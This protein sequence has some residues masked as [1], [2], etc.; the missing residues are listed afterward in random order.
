MLLG[1]DVVD[2][3]AARHTSERARDR[4]AARILGKDAAES[5]DRW[6]TNDR[7][8]LL[9]ALFA[10]KE[11]A[12]KA[13]SRR[14]PGLVFAH[15]EFVVAPDLRCVTHRGVVLA[16]EIARGDGWVH[17]LAFTP[18]ARPTWALAR[19]GADSDASAAARRLLCAHAA[20][21]L[22]VAPESLTV[23][24]DPRPGS[25]DGFGPPRLEPRTPPGGGA[26]APQA[27]TPHAP[28]SPSTPPRLPVPF[29]PAIVSLAHHGRFVS[30]AHLA[31]DRGEARD[32]VE[33][34]A[35]HVDLR[36]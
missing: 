3:D 11:A 33:R 15:A 36:A 14:A 27:T 30:C 1:D 12:Y 4:F 5:L 7:E 28:L 22:G 13:L 24:R 26:W 23:V 25:W 21:R 10:A 16:L 20:P 29:L 9:W 19:A 32:R 8:V 17:A 18:G 35:A 6:H 31:L 34:T 2:T